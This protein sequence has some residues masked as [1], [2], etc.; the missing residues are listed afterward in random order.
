MVQGKWEGGGGGAKN[1]QAV[2][3]YGIHNTERCCN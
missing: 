2:E 1:E 3:K